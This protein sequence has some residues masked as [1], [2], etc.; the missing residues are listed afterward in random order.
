[1]FRPLQL[2]GHL[3]TALL[4]YLCSRLSR[5]FNGNIKLRLDTAKHSTRI[6]DPLPFAFNLQSNLARYLYTQALRVFV[7]KAAVLNSAHSVQLRPGLTL[8]VW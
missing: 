3:I 5:R 4:G 8:N 1:M 6:A 2:V 7:Q